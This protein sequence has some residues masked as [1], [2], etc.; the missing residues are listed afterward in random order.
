MRVPLFWRILCR[1]SRACRAVT[2][3]KWGITAFARRAVMFLHTL[4]AVF[5]CFMA[6][7]MAWTSISDWAFPHFPTIYAKYVT[8]PPP[9]SCCWRKL[10]M[11][12]WQPYHIGI[13]WYYLWCNGPRTSDLGSI[14]PQVLLN[15]SFWISELEDCCQTS[16]RTYTFCIF[17]RVSG[18]KGQ[19]N[20]ISW[21]PKWRLICYL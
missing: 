6:S 5:G 14:T 9:R 4:L 17:Y 11:Q 8:K 15:Y 20:D 12:G 2:D 16:V 10:L 1:L 18:W 19:V 7:N 13:K 21:A 3:F